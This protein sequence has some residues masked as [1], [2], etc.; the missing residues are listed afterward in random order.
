MKRRKF[1]KNLGGGILILGSGVVSQAWADSNAKDR[2]PH[3]NSN[4]KDKN[5]NADSNVNPRT[6]KKANPNATSQDST[7]LQKGKNM[8]QTWYITAAS[9]GFGLELAKYAL[10]K[11]DK[12]AGTSRNL[13]NII[14][15]L[16]AESENF[17]PLELKFDKNMESNMKA[18][19]EAI[20]EKFGRIDNL[21][22]NAGYG[23]L[24][25]VEEVS[26][27]DLRAQFEVNVFAPFI[28]TQNALKIMRPQAL[29]EGG[30]QNNI[31]ARIFNISS[32]GGFRASSVS[33]PYCMS[34]FAL[35]ALSEG[36][37]LDLAPF[38]IHT[39][40]VMPGGF[41]TE[42]VGESLRLG[43]RAISDYDKRREAF[44]SRTKSYN[45]KQA[46][47]PAKFG[48]VIFK[49]SRMEKPPFS[50]FMSDSA[51]KSARNKLEWVKEEME[52]TQ[53]YAG[54]AM[55]FADSA[56]SAFDAR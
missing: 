34:K 56:G 2:N 50:L 55:D 38:G 22:N 17:L 33:T 48:E 35:S 52:S 9:G 7:D 19:L 43:D 6:N 41:R 16:G 26:E 10:S 30:S 37:L 20:R 1:L 8:Q 40:N 12:V 39:I 18:N 27:E 46:G 4:A 23:L 24:G 31:R 15:K 45:G 3:T 44:L 25:F 54:V 11:G 28:L 29:S 42:F 13:K 49:I 53:S 47:N 21:V 14:A 32:I 36:L 51:Y 5:Q